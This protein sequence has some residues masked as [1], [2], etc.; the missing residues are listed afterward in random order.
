METTQSVF[1]VCGILPALLM[2]GAYGR[3]GKPLRAFFGTAV[4]GVIS[5]AV[6]NYAS[7]FTGVG[8]IVNL[9]TLF[10]AVFLGLPGVI[11]IFIL[12]IMWGI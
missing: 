3:T 6:I 2:L 11:S 1:I 5:L 12:K 9:T 8:L 10:S 7:F 4:P